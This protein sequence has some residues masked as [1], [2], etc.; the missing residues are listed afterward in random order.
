MKKFTSILAF[1]LCVVMIAGVV[2]VAA[3][4]AP[5]VKPS[6]ERKQAPE[7]AKVVVIYSDG[8]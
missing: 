7:V 5:S 4:T 2:C 3:E 1:V 6:V 8:T